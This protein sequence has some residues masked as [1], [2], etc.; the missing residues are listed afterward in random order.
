MGSYFKL[1][2]N[3]TDYE[4][5]KFFYVVQDR[6]QSQDLAGKVCTFSLYWKQKKLCCQIEQAFWA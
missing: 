3:E 2:P 6:N 5:M 1:D 4:D